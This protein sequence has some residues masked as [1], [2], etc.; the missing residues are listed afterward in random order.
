M[1]GTY[2]VPQ[3]ILN[4]PYDPPAEHWHIVEGE[5]PSRV[6][7]RR[8]AVYFYRDPRARDAQGQIAGV[9][10]ELTLVNLVRERLEKWRAEGYPGVTRTTWNCSSGRRATAGTGGSSSPSARRPRRSSS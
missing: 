5:Q 1:S 10:V 2:E 3:P 7:G 8:R 4:S 6:Q 9:P